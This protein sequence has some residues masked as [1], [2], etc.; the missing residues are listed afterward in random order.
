MSLSESFILASPV[1]NALLAALLFAVAVLLGL[2]VSLQR[3]LYACRY[4]IVR[5]INEKEEL[6]K[7]LPPEVPYK[8][9]PTQLTKTELLSI[10]K[11][12][13]HLLNRMPGGVVE[14]LEQPF[15]QQNGPE[16]PRDT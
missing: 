11:I 12:V 3:K 5:L 1:E 9:H 2:L 15:S 4:V 6:K 7:M 10:V 13:N 8:Y 14:Y 16:K